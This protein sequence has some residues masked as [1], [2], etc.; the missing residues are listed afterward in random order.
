MFVRVFRRLPSLSLVVSLLAL[1]V[2]LG[3]WGYAATGG[4]LILGRQNSA[5]GTTRLSSNSKRGPSLA[6]KNT[7]GQP[8]ASFS[9]RNGVAPF[10]V[11]SATKVARLNAALLDG[12]G[13]SS[14]WSLS[15]NAGTNPGTDFLGTKD[16]KPLV[17]KTNN[18]EALRVNADGTVSVDN[19]LT[20]GT[21]SAS[22]IALSGRASGRAIVGNLGQSVC[23]RG[24]AFAVGGCDGASSLT[25]LFGSTDSGVYGSSLSGSGVRGESPTGR[26]I[27]GFS[28]NGIGV[29]GNSQT[30]GVI[31]TLNRSSCAGTYGVGGCGST[32]GDGVLGRT[33]VPANSFTA[34]AVHAINDGGGDIFIGEASGARRA[35]IDGSGK[36]FFNGGTQTGGADYAESMRTAGDPAAMQPGDVLAVDPQHGYAVEKSRQPNSRLLVGVYSTRPAVLAV[37]AH[38]IDDSLA[39]EVPVAL[40]GVVPTKVTTANGPIKAGDLLT[41]SSTPGYAMRAAHIVIGGMEIYPTGAI[42]GKA[43]E[44]LKA[45]KGIIKVLVMLR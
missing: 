14:F 34:A 22:G 6:V 13:S 39:H 12:L 2:A 5:A 1:F 23:P 43:L 17:V 26:A 25:S 28:S 36:G 32:V 3:G 24:P 9:V 21:A 33:S 42:L 8:A 31:G 4:S 20:A 7:G 45:G 10:S 29:I 44:P 19:T 30:R 40:L 16:A 15:G 27:E 41:T 35:R 18:T 37:G 11:G 38:G